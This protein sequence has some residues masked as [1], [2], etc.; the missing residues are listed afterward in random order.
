MQKRFLTMPI[1]AGLA[2]RLRHAYHL[3]DLSSRVVANGRVWVKRGMIEAVGPGFDAPCRP[4]ARPDQTLVDTGSCGAGRS[5]TFR[6][7][8]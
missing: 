1:P 3:H 5:P 4:E 8:T 2:D 7:I 6:F